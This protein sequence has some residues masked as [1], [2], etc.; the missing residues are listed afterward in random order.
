MHDAL[1]IHQWRYQPQ[2][3][4]NPR[5]KRQL[6]MCYADPFTLHCGKAGIGGGNTP[7]WREWE[8]AVCERCEWNVFLVVVLRV[9]W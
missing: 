5:D 4:C 1:E 7:K 8:R 6:Q 9:V 2:G 3:I